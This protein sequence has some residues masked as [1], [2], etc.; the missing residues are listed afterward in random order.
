MNFLFQFFF[1]KI[2]IIKLKVYK[3]KK[4][5]V[6]LIKIESANKIVEHLKD[7]ETKKTQATVVREL[8]GDTLIEVI[9]FIKFF[10]LEYLFFFIL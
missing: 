8:M 6:A 3:E 7:P 4:S 1:H 5:S 9:I 10:E 2:F